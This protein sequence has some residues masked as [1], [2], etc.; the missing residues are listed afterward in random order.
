MTWPLASRAA[1]LYL[2]GMARISKTGGRGLK[3]LPRYR[4]QV[5]ARHGRAAP[6][7]WQVFRHGESR[8]VEQSESGYKTEADAWSAGGG[9]V[10]RLAKVPLQRGG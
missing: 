4:V 9:A 1:P 8:P 3:A 7:G 2:G 10:T 5:S 6:W